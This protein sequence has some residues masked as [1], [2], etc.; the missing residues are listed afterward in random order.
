MFRL[1]MR[2]F[3]DHDSLSSAL[4]IFLIQLDEFTLL[5]TI[6]FQVKT[7]LERVVKYHEILQVVKFYGLLFIHCCHLCS[8]H[9]SANTSLFCS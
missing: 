7:S 1:D 3:V 6:I 2:S 4:F 8:L 5:L 9:A